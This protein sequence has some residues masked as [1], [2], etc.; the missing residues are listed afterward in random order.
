MAHFFGSSICV[1]ALLGCGGNVVVDGAT[2]TS[3]GSTATGGATGAGGSCNSTAEI[4]GCDV[5]A[6]AKIPIHTCANLFM[7][8]PTC[9]CTA[10]GGTGGISCDGSASFLGVCLST[11][12]GVKA[13]IVYFSDG[14]VTLAQATAACVNSGGMWY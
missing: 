12:G 2:A 5:P 1:F 3:G 7:P 13:K 11:L 9:V 10:V 14:G 8:I 6:T 4:N